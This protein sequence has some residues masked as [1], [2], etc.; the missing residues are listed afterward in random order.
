VSDR[1]RPAGPLQE[2]PARHALPV[3]DVNTAFGTLPVAGPDCSLE[4]LLRLMERNGVAAA[5]THSMVGLT[6]HDSEG[7]AATH[8]ACRADDRLFPAAV[9]MPGVYLD[10]RSRLAASLDAGCRLVRLYPEEHGWSPRSQ[11]FE[12]LVAALGDRDLRPPLL[13]SSAPPA[14]LAD[15]ARATEGTGV[16][17]ILAGVNYATLGECLAL[18]RRYAHVYLET[19]RAASPGTVA[20][21]VQEAGHTRLLFGSGAPWRP[22]APALNVVLGASIA[23]EARAAIL[24]GNLCR[25][26]GISV[27]SLPR[28]P[29]PPVL[30]AYRGPIVDV[31]T[32]LGA[33]TWRFPITS[34]GTPGLMAVLREAGIERAIASSIFAITTDLREGNDRLVAALSESPGLYGYVTVNPQHFDASA[35]E[36]A[37]LAGHPRMVGVKIHAEYSRTATSSP[38]MQR[39][40]AE[41]ARYSMPVK[42]HN[43]GADWMPALA[44][45]ARAHPALPIIVA[46]GGGRGT[47]PFFRDHPN[48]NFEF[49]SSA[50]EQG[51]IAECLRAVGPRRILFGSDA[52]L[53]SPLYVLGAYADAEI[54]D[55][56]APLVY[57]DNAVR[58]FGL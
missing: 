55:D 14:D 33:G 11:R 45:L 38:L 23:A 46:H 41:L 40:F 1:S 21:V 42:I 22:M 18:L 32:H 37:R 5:V 29:A 36:L 8:R 47:G 49:C 7:D 10:W 43:G 57:H 48:V 50:P 27:E 31:H 6:Y 12:G 3:L 54:P 19:S 34:V 16:P 15:Y 25:L 39:L 52:D 30:R 53:I 26:L 44:A 13:L 35:A 20:L 56:A 17:L 2:E 51:V 4:S 58:L 28:T 9:V 24:A